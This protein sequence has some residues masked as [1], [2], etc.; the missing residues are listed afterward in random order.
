MP[1]AR[2]PGDFTL[3]ENPPLILSRI[4][5]QVGAGCKPASKCRGKAVVDFY[6]NRAAIA[7]SGCA[8]NFFVTR[9]ERDGRLD[10]LPSFFMYPGSPTGFRATDV[11]SP[12][13]RSPHLRNQRGSPAKRE[14]TDI[15]ALA[16][17]SLSFGVSVRSWNT[18]RHL[19]ET[20]TSRNRCHLC[21][22][23]WQPS[24]MP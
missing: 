21:W 6:R 12:R 17:P 5:R 7:R 18:S 24:R 13:V 23:R 11:V 1:A 20:K 19:R 2:Y 9:L 4:T 16:V 15:R 22:R 14:K 3:S 10:A 8:Q